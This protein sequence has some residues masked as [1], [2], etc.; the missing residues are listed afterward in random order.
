MARGPKKHLKRINAP[1]HWM[2]DKLGGVWAP[3]PSSGPH[4]LRECL[5]LIIMLRNRMKYA[6]TR[7]EV[8][9]IVMQKLIKVDGKVRTDMCFPAGFMDVISIDRVHEH[10]RLL[11]D[12]KGRFVIHRISDAEAKYKLVRVRERFT[13][14]GG[15]PY[16][17]THDG[18]TFRYPHPEIHANDTVKYNIETHELLEFVKFEVGNLAMVTGGHNLGRVGLIM[19]RERHPGSFE[20]IHLKDAVG[21]EFSTRINNVFCIG[22]GSKSLIT[23]PRGK[24]VRKS[25]L[26]EQEQRYKLEKQ[27]AA[28]VAASVGKTPVVK[29]E[30]SKAP[31]KPKTE[32]KEGKVKHKKVKHTSFTGQ[33]ALP[34][35]KAKE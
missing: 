32:A 19:R 13:G 29:K 12:T 35:K 7:R 16:I 10:F 27:K 31:A 8:L 6:L 5:P 34:V 20:I 23:L 4:K 9:A 33:F 24:G 15:V 14:K 1:R 25:I 22:K 11:Y 30:K 3:R 17:S 28:A 26:E 21:H 2:L 18:R